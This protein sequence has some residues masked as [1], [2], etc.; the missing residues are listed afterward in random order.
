MIPSEGRER[1]DFQREMEFGLQ[2]KQDD[3]R[4]DNEMRSCSFLNNSWTLTQ[5]ETIPF[6]WLFSLKEPLY[7][8]AA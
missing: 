1:R 2:C 8:V 7:Y 4:L 5:V 6:Y 3:S